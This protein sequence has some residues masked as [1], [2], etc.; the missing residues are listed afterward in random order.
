MHSES[1]KLWHSNKTK[2]GPV[3]P[4]PIQHNFLAGNSATVQGSNYMY[5]GD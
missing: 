2:S 3:L 5:G 4:P 1:G